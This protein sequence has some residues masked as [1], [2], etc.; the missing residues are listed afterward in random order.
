[1][2][3]LRSLPLT[4]H[5][6]HQARRQ[7]TLAS[8][9]STVQ[10]PP[11]VAHRLSLF[12]S[13]QQR[14][15]GLEE[16]VVEDIPMPIQHL[17]TTKQMK[18]NLNSDDPAV[19][20]EALRTYWHSAAHVLGQ[21][22]ELEL[23]EALLCDGPALVGEGSDRGFYY[24]V[25]LPKNVVIDDE[26]RNDLEK[27]MKLIAREKQTFERIEITRTFASELFAENKY[28]LSLLERIPT[29]ETISVY[30]N[31]PFVDLCR[32]PHMS[33]TSLFGAIKLLKTSASHFRIQ[34][35]QQQQQQQQQQ[36]EKEMETEISH[37]SQDTTTTGNGIA[38]VMEPV[39]RVYGIAF[40]KPKEL[41]LY[42]KQMK[43]AQERDH[44]LIGT[45]Q[46]LFMFDAS[47]PGSPFF[48]P[49]GTKIINRLTQVR[50]FCCFLCTLFFF[51][52]RLLVF[53]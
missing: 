18:E 41:K 37:I 46:Q 40:R 32:G 14:Q 38:E 15:Q 35:Q 28:K 51:V 17:V 9:A 22:M 6:L 10:L 43:L 34:E 42:D 45:Q 25:A 11:A 19:V 24:Q 49:H 31:G 29:A 8:G 2:F 13:E 5:A 52:P 39:Q 12:L 21:A 27:T 47:S 20:T 4:R 33:D 36:P 50:F 3:F 26:K 44:R 30:R 16:V 1:M 7:S 48:L 23:P 53:F